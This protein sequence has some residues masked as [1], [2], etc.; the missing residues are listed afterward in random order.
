MARLEKT[1]E[2]DFFGATASEKAGAI[3]TQEKNQERNQPTSVSI[4]V[5]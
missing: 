1:G 2:E 3:S 5:G 4:I